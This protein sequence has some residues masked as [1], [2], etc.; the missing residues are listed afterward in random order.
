M[1]LSQSDID[2]IRQ[3]VERTIERKMRPPMPTIT[4]LAAEL[5]VSRRT[6]LRRMGACGIPRRD[7]HGEAVGK[8]G[9]YVYREE[10]EAKERLS[11]TVV[12]REAPAAQTTRA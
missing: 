12:K 11:D 6:V 9:K 2:A 1:N 5:G 7:M 10:W 3:T 8:G 4:D